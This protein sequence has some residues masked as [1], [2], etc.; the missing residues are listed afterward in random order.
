MVVFDILKE[1][2]SY[3]LAYLTISSYTYPVYFLNYTN[4]SVINL[5][6]LVYL[7][8]FISGLLHIFLDNYTGDNPY[9]KPH[10]QG[11][12]NHHADPK[13]FTQREIFTVF[14][15]PGHSVILFNLINS[16]FLNFYFL[17][18]TGLVNI[19]QLTHYQA[20]CINH[21][22]F[23]KSVADFFIILQKY[24]I[25]LSTENHSKHH[26]TFDNNFCILTGWANPVLNKCYKILN[27]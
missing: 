23:S 9:I 17:I 16:Y 6:L 24:G 7:A 25:I 20:H 14:T 21:K 1:T 27:N 15:E 26:K 18:F 5:L 2:H 12:Q 19:V 8:D 4:V 11:F 13:E 22:T 10:A 3:K